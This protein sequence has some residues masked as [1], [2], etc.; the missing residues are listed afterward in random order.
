MNF[1]RF[2][3]YEGFIHENV[4]S[5]IACSGHM[6]RRLLIKAKIHSF[7]PPPKKAAEISVVFALFCG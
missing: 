2:I 6:P 3:A 1:F 7:R 4:L 5:K